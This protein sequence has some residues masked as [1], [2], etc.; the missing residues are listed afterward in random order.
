MRNKQFFVF[1]ICVLIWYTA[2]YAFVSTFSTLS[3]SQD[4]FP[5]LQEYKLTKRDNQ[6]DFRPQDAITRGET[7]K[8]VSQYAGAVGLN[9]VWW[10]C[11]F[12]DIENYDGTLR[13]YI[14]QACDYW[15]LQW[16]QGMFYPEQSLTEAQALAMVVRSIYGYQDETGTPWY[17]EYIALG[18]E[19]G[20][21]EDETTETLAT[22]WITREKLATWLYSAFQYDETDEENIYNQEDDDTESWFIYETD[23]ESSED[24]TSYET[25]DAQRN[26]CYFECDTEAECDD[27]ATQIDEEL[28]SW[29]DT[30]EDEQRVFDEESWKESSEQTTVVVYTVTAWEKITTKTGND[31]P[32]YQTIRQEVAEIS[33]NTISDTYLESFEIFNDPESDV[34]AFVADDDGNWKWH[35]AIN[36]PAHQNS[37]I[38]EQKATIIHE[39]SHIITLNNDQMNSSNGVCGA[40]ETDEGCTKASSYLN[41]FY[42]TFWKNVTNPSFDEQQFVTDYATTNV[43]EDIAESFAFFILESNH[44][45][46]TTRNQKVHFFNTFSEL[47][48]M[49]QEIR[50]VLAKYAIRLKKSQ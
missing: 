28:D 31:I 46:N 39:L 14:P 29:T 33:P 22:T 20:F 27:I 37:D 32:E 1:F 17:I 18:R 3:F 47:V 5:R 42:Q 49:R 23:V 11:T 21:L 25:Y 16:S 44:Q 12:S 41:Q 19:I 30:L 26:V 6:T 45:T 9:T 38:K 34:L 35:M 8:F 13:D 4:V 7:A 43:E 48:T 10:K 2:V 24:C 40:Y 15:L 50:S 36:L